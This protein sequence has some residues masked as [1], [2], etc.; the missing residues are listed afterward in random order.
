MKLRLKNTV[1]IGFAFLSVTVLWQA[2]NWLVP[3]YLDG[4]LRGLT[5]GNEF[6]I[7]VVMGLDNL[8]AV[9]MIPFVSAVSDR[10]K[11]ET[12]SRMKLISLGITLAGAAFCC[13]PLVRDNLALM[14]LSLVTVL[15]AMNL[16]RGPSAALMPD[17]TPE[18]LRGKANAVI[19]IMGGIGTAVGYILLFVGGL[20]G[21]DSGFTVCAVAAVM[22][23]CLAVLLCAAD[24]N[25][26]TFGSVCPP[27]A[28]GAKKGA[29]KIAAKKGL[30]AVLA[31]VFFYFM[32]T[33]AVETFMS[34]YSARVLK[35]TTAGLVLMGALAVGTFAF[36]YPAA[37]LAQ[38][39]GYK[40]IMLVGSCLMAAGGIF[41]AF[42][43][44]F[45]LLLVPSFFVIG[46][47][48]AFMVA[49]MYPLVLCFCGGDDFA[50]YSGYY[51]AATMLAQSVTPVIS[52]L[53]F[54]PWLFGSMR[55]LMPYASVFMALCA[56]TLFFAPDDA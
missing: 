43:G 10:Q 54:S 44:S 49:N 39:H 56:I 17:T 6:L 34:I 21:W 55:A 27:S 25:A 37:A 5:G 40:K 16:Y 20:A 47:G 29:K 11:R 38:K 8:F 23:V 22:F 32:A 42:F 12:G 18:P 50:K 41:S 24:E 3:L 30:G 7:G 53:L 51:Y 33:N 36:M 48:M 19:N 46:V 2:Y 15:T 14:L 35:N 31:S 45:S 28:A 9:V 4:Y 13:L 1:V 26:N 52:G